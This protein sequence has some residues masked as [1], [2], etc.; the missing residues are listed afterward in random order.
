MNGDLICKS[1]NQLSEDSSRCESRYI[2]VNQKIHLFN[3]TSKNMKTETVI[4]DDRDPPL[5]NST[6]KGLIQEK[7]IAKK[8]Y[9]Q[10]NKLSYFE[11]LSAFKIS[12]LPQLKNP[13]NSFIL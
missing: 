5:I 1:I 11:D 12:E 10:S 4:C 3:Q 13:K 6:R 7:N 8:F 2:D 9:L